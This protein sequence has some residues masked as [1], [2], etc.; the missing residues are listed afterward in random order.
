M[1]G[2]V[3]YLLAPLRMQQPDICKVPGMLH[4]AVRSASVA[5]A[6]FRPPQVVGPEDTMKQVREIFMSKA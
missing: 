3:L 4:H 1:R 6:C 5:P 2:S